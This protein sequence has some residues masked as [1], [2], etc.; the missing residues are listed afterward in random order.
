[1][2]MPRKIRPPRANTVTERE[3]HVMDYIRK[4]LVMNDQLPTN[5]AISSAFGWASPNAASE[6]LCSLESK[7][8]LARNELDNL[9]LAR[10]APPPARR[11]S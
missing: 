11:R 3:R 4:F 8:Q 7:G 10:T 2:P 9:M 1:M 6:I 5:K